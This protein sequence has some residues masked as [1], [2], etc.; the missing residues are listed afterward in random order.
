MTFPLLSLDLSADYR[1]KP[2]ALDHVQFEI[3]AGECFGLIGESGSGKSTMALAVMRLLEM[4]GGRVR[5]SLLFEGRDLLRL[6]GREMRRIR[7]CRIALVPQSPLSA[8]NPVLRLE[9]HLR[10]AWGLHSRVGWRDAREEVCDL[11]RR[12]GLPS[13]D[14]FLRRFP[15]QVSV[16]QAQRVLIAMAVLHRPSL[17]IADEP[18]SA[19]D[20]S[21][22]REILALLGRL[23]RDYGMA[24]L[25][26]SHDLPSVVEFCS[27]V[28]VLQGGR[29]IRCGPI[30]QGAIDIPA[31]PLFNYS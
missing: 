12:M 25:Y 19:L 3:E 2:A 26:I 24:M 14:G 8:L 23:N 18:T 29:L 27:R 7:G 5:G 16:G 31:K 15:H 4:R 13:D 11:L 22:Q 20:P 21:S 9:T 17:L 6:S 30:Q 1:N 10:E 28:G